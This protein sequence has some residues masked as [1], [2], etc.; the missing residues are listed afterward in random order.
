M[1]FLRH[2]LMILGTAALSTVLITA[3]LNTT[4]LK[5]D[6]WLKKADEAKVYAAAE[7][8]VVNQTAQQA[9]G[10][11]VKIPSAME[12]RAEVTR[13]LPELEDYIRHGGPAPVA[14]FGDPTSTVST[15][16]VIPNAANSPASY[17]F[18]KL[19]DWQLPLAIASLVLAVLVALT[20][21]ARKRLFAL[22]EFA[23]WSAAG[24]G[25]WWL[26]L[27]L[28]PG[29]AADRLVVG[30]D[31]A[32]YVPVMRLWVEAVTK[33]TNQLVLLAIIALGVVA[34]VLAVAQIIVNLRPRG[35]EIAAGSASNLPILR[36]PE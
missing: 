34:A 21:H 36:R 35:H 26:A 32:P 16:K 25:I 4:L 20:S 18:G 12:W 10:V 24:L 15:K 5:A 9:P 3:I 1:R 27:K 6:Y 7:E 23:I 13:F 2:L 11:P 19:L 30:P 29:L 8:V 17:W 28:L 31:V 22:T 14:P 33:G